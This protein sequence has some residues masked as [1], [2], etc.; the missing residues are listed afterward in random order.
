MKESKSRTSHS[1]GE[2]TEGKDK[3]FQFVLKE[4]LSAYHPVLEEELKRA[5]SPEQLEDEAAE[6]RNC[7]EE[8]ELANRLFE[9]FASEKVALSYLPEEAR[10]LL[11]EPQRWRWCLLHIRCC[12]IFG[13]LVCRGPR[14]FRS[15]SYYLHHYWRCVRQVLGTPVGKTLTA[16]E[17]ED[18]EVLV[19][20]LAKAYKPF[21]TNQLATVEYP[22]GTHEAVIKGETDC[23]TDEEEICGIF[24]RLF[25]TETARA[26]LGRATYEKYSQEPFF[27]FCRCWCLCALCLGC[28]LARARNIRAIRRCLVEY[29]RCLR[30]CFRPLTCELTAPAKCVQEK[31]FPALGIFRGVEIRGTAAGAFCSHYTLRWRQ[32]GVGPWHSNS[33]VYPGGAPQGPCG[34]VG[35][36]L[37]YL[38]TMPMVAAGLVEIQLC[39]YSSQPNVAPC[40][41][42]IFFELQ[43]NLVWI[44]GIEGVQAT[45]PL[46]SPPAPPGSRVFDQFD[47]TAQLT[48]GTVVKSFGTALRV[49]GSAVVGGCDGQ[50]IKRYTLSYQQG[51]TTTT[52]GAWTQFWQVDYNTPFQIDAGMNKVFERELTSAWYEMPFCFVDP[53]PVPHVVCEVADDYLSAVYWSTQ[54]PEG[55][56][57]V[58]F[59]DPPGLYPDPAVGSW[60][61]V[62]LASPN[63]QSGRYTLR[64]TVEDTVGNTTDNLRQVWFDN[65]NIYGKIAQI[66]AIPSCATINLSTFA[67]NADCAKP[68]PAPLMGLAY[69]ELIEEGNTSNP[70]DNYGGYTLEIKKDG[71]S[72]HS[73]QIPG[74]GNP[75]WG[76]PFT[77]TSRV[78]EPGVR[79]ANAVPP[80]VGIPPASNG[81]LTMLDM[82]RLDAVCNPNS[83]G[84]DADLVLQ[85]GE[86]CGFIVY[87]HVWDTSICPSLSGGSHTIDDYFPFCICNDLP[88]IS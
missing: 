18:F 52:A 56:F 8:L 4:L 81:I 43:R 9:R 67:G 34:I 11:G 64:L 48:V 83:G 75:P 76:A 39:V 12:L 37:G 29:W 62:P 44:T 26:L 78:G 19:G 63:C 54:V 13:W 5:K 84:A 31:E 1:S 36:I 87:L 17:K 69:D 80:P 59:T 82:R 46:P 38:K 51:F 33:I 20:G 86:C 3:D 32:S 23:F 66:G 14:T 72:W 77:G 40:C 73:I 45:V 16:E 58:Q 60:N 41:T 71:G 21:L 50:D 53:F 6:A 68:W 25:N 57:P 35:G 27:W 10:K 79:C 28:C 7:E 24:E 85:R 30:N 22:L 15:W 2:F 42:T 55:P 49:F 61:S 74:P 65:K 88:A 70:S 47:P